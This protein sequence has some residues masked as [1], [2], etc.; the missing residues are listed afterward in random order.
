MSAL[1]HQYIERAT[2]LV[3]TERLARDAWI[4]WLYGPVREHAPA[5]MRAF[6]SGR[7]TDRVGRWNYDRPLSFDRVRRARELADCGVVAEE[8]VVPPERY[9]TL[10]EVFER[11]IRYWECRPAPAS[12]RAVLSPAD[13][14]MLTGSFADSFGVMIKEKLFGL[15]ALIGAGRG[16][17]S[18]R[19]ERASF[20][21]LR[22]TPDKYHFTHTPVAGGVADVYEVEGLCHSCNPGAL[23]HLAGAYAL[24][25]RHVTIFD[26]DVPGGTGAG[27]VAMIEV[28]AL[29]IG[30][31]DPCYSVT[32][33]EQPVPLATG[34]RVEAGR[35]KALF[36]PGSST[37]VLLFEPGRVEFSPDLVANGRRTDVSSRFSAGFG[38]PLVETELRV[39][40]GIAE[41][42]S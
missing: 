5:L 42:L 4:R 20:A 10:R 28:V 8:C 40:E 29:M 26:T 1:P 39:R 24:N 27:F 23:V 12:P 18:R 16:E 9:S 11:R 37:V 21:V 13:A 36:R 35:P 6:A 19:F 30:R 3:R 14:R 17:W 34:M 41:A 25:R 38:A 2:G 22:L 15:P 31:I 33:Y 32:E 7:W